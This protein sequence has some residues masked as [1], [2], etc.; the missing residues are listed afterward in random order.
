MDMIFAD[1]RQQSDQ[2]HA[3]HRSKLESKHRIHHNCSRADIVAS[4]QSLLAMPQ[5]DRHL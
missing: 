5:C 2:H 4:N 3:C 1:M